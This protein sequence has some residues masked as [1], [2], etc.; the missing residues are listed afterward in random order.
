MAEPSAIDKETKEPN[1]Q[2][3]TAALL[4]R[5]RRTRPHRQ[6]LI[7]DEKQDG[8]CALVSRGPASRRQATI[9]LR[10]CFYLPSKPGVP[11]YIK[12]GRYPDGEHRYKD[13]KGI[14]HIISC[15]DLEKVHARASAV[16]N[17][18]KDGINPR[19]EVPSDS[20]PKVVENF[21]NLYA[22]KKN[23]TWDETERVF[24]TYV[25]PEWKDRKI[26]DITRDDIT[27]L[28]DKIEQGKIK[29]KKRGYIGATI[30]ADATLTQL[31][32]LFNWY[33]LR[34]DG[35]RSPIV[36]GMRRGKPS[37]DRARKRWLTDAELRVMWP[38]LNEF[39]IYGA[40]IKTALLTGLR[41]H[42]V[43]T[44]RR[45]DLKQR[46]RVASHIDGDQ[47][48]PE[49][50][51]NDVWDPT[52]DDDP[53]NKGVAVVPLSPMVR[54][55]IDAV[56]ISDGECD[57]VFSLNGD[58]PIK[59]WGRFKHRLDE[60]MAKKLRKLG[61]DFKPWQQRDLRRTAKTLMM[62]AGVTRDISERCLGHAI[63]GVEEVYDRY[64]YLREKRDAFAKLAAL[65]ERIVNPPTGNVVALRG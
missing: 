49:S 20:F 45:G 23:L 62:R 63:G 30:Q 65:I 6:Y 41:F 8:L 44:M 18:A 64:D 61:E 19:W 51:I 60:A 52:R 29:H 16:R 54:A 15:S 57:Y 46:M 55:I 22:K 32:K 48:V 14:E 10:V 17:N 12:I 56:P 36:K 21:L 7:W 53:R 5:L 59:G 58:Q 50:F 2:K 42:K 26:G 1:K 43:S 3:F 47:H 39:G 33:A 40:V 11:R 27:A 34:K 38:T 35:F 25:L 4:D 24:N 28:L 9:T 13:A 31:S 37:K